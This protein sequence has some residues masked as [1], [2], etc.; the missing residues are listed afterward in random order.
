MLNLFIKRNGMVVRESIQSIEAID[1]SSDVLWI[2]LL[3]PSAQ[4]IAYISKTYLLDIPTK[5]EREEIE[6]SARYWEDSESVTI[7]TYFLTRPNEENILHNETITFLLTHNILFTVR[8]SE[9]KVFDEIQQR[10]LASP[11]NFEDGFDLI[12]K[13]FELRVEKDADMLESIAKQTRLLR[14]AVVFDK[15]LG[16]DI[17][18]NLSIL[19]EM[20]L[21]LRDSLFDKRLAITA[22]LRTNKAD[23]EVK[24]D[25]GIVLKDI[26]SLVEF[27]N[28]N[29]NILDN[30]QTLFSSQINIEQNKTIKIFTVVTVAMMPPTLISTIYGMNFKYMPELEWTYSYPIVLG[31]MIISTVLPILYFKKKKWL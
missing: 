21:S 10:V 27:T 1:A 9:F 28:V 3:H 8:Y 24:K 13:I 12:S 30:I 2:D 29:M 25:L 7:N 11:K 15:K 14:R 4:E 5:E 31:V 6:E 18:E 26:N 22:L 16:D 17:L 23:L 19:Q 20:H